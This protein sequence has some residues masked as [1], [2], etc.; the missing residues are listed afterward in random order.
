MSFT[1]ERFLLFFPCSILLY[2][3]SPFEYRPFSLLIMSVVFYLSWGWHGFA[4]VI[5][6][7]LITFF[8]ARFIA[9]SSNKKEKRFWLIISIVLLL[10]ALIYT[11]AGKYLLLLI[12]STDNRMIVPLGISYITLSSLGYL[13]DVYRGQQ[14]PENNFL[15]FL[16]FLLYFPKVIQGPISRYQELSHELFSGHEFDFKRVC[17]GLQLMLYGLFKKLVIADR[18]AVVISTIFGNY[19]QYKGSILI[20]GLILRSIQLYCDFSGYMDI[21]E[22]ISEVFGISLPRNFSHPFFS[23]SA[24]E[25]WRRWHM[26]MGQW[27][28]DYVYM[29]LVTSPTVSKMAYR[30]RQRFG[31]RTG[32]AFM[33]LL[34]LIVVWILTG[35]WHGTGLNYLL[36]GIYWGLIISFSTVFTKE[37]KSLASM[38]HID[39]E[40]KSWML[41][42]QIRTFLLFT[43]AR[44]IV[45]EDAIPIWRKIKEGL[46]IGQL[47]DGT[48]YTLG[49]S[50]PEFLITFLAIGIV[51]EI[52]ILQENGSVRN[53]I[54][55]SNVVFRWLIY[56][57]VIFVIIIFGYY[58]LGYNSADFI[59][60]QF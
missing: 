15:R 28:K 34:P 50:R 13:I 14:Q 52:S 32:K 16:L 21:A 46:Y 8:L 18:M 30:I 49:I 23:Q 37:L 2:F 22:G 54:A 11:K 29:P 41:F 35:L 4:F 39:T 57:I 20:F 12:R 26:S 9:C 7:S 53:L 60:M 40:K 56:Y 45:L 59:Y 48:I 17:F 47:F 27:F 10:T 19:K 6:L 24:G 38:L 43:F 1:D 31:K 25:F 42:R 51:W 58:G 3:V 36:W 33:S 44:F 5:L 55:D